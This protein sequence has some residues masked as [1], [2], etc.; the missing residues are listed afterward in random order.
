MMLEAADGRVFCG[1]RAAW[2]EYH[3]ST[4]FTRKR[5]VVWKSERGTRDFGHS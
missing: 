4:G 5:R 3:L 1:A 2:R